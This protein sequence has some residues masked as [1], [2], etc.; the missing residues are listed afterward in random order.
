MSLSAVN[1]TTSASQLVA[2]NSLR[3]LLVIQ[4]VSDTDVFLKFDESATEVTTANGILLSSAGGKFTLSSGRN[5][6]VYAVRGIHGGSGN[7]ELRIQ[8]IS[9]NS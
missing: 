3:Q 1:C 2:A 9:F 6:H 4:N 8:E 5:E 7:K